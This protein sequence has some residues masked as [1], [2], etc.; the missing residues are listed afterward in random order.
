MYAL[1][2]DLAKFITMKNSA[3]VEDYDDDIDLDDIE[4]IPTQPNLTSK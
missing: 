3:L 4:N 2:I 1:N